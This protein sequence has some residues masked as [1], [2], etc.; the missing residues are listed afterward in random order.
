M[1]EDER[2]PAPVDLSWVTT[3]TI[4]PPG[5]TGW[6]LR[7]FIVVNCLAFAGIMTYLMWAAVTETGR[8]W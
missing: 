1:L 7:I 3:E 4:P 6:P 8:C 2:R 5:G